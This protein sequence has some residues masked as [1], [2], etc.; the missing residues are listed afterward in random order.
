[1]AEWI[2]VKDRLPDILIESNSVK[3]TDT[4]IATDGELRAF[5][6]FTI[7]K[8]DGSFNFYGV[9]EDNLDSTFTYES[10]I[11]THWMPLP[12]MPEGE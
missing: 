10:G 4:V 1:M 5:G 2:S 12:P 8:Y 7:Y 3:V 6:Y 9:D 11:I